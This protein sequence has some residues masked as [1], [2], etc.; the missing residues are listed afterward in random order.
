MLRHLASCAC[1]ASLLR[2]RSRTVDKKDNRVVGD[3]VFGVIVKS[4]NWD[5]NPPPPLSPKHAYKWTSFPLGHNDISNLSFRCEI[6]GCW[7]ALTTSRGETSSNPLRS[8][9]APNGRKMTNTWK[10]TKMTWKIDFSK[11]WYFFVS[12]DLEILKIGDNG[13]NPHP[14]PTGCWYTSNLNYTLCAIQF[15]RVP[16][17]SRGRVGVITIITNFQNF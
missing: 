16:A 15:G 12:D 5:S 4:T 11:I 8:Q 3:S 10:L 7:L 17:P 2:H 13:D 1:K 14:S 9:F 6:Q